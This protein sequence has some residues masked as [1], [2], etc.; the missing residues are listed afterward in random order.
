MAPFGLTADF[1]CIAVTVA[2]WAPEIFTWLWWHIPRRS[3]CAYI[4]CRHLVHGIC[5]ARSPA[6]ASAF[7]WTGP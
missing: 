5:R 2:P 7:H 6:A 4:R 1:L 3:Q